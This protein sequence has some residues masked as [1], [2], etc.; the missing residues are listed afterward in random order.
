MSAPSSR[1]VRPARIAAVV[2]GG[3]LVLALA[4]ASVI[5]VG[6][7]FWLLVKTMFVAIGHAIAEAFRNAFKR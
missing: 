7:L 2:L 6:L 1:A 4:V 3:V 5:G